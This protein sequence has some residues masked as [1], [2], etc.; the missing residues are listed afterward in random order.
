MENEVDRF[1]IRKPRG[2]ILCNHALGQSGGLD[3][4]WIDAAP[5][6]GHLD[7]DLVGLLISPE[8]DVRVTGFANGD[9]LLRRFDAV[10][11]AIAHN[12][13]QRFSQRGD[14][15]FIRCCFLA[16]HLQVD[17]LG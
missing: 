12:V 2:L 16:L 5:V 6:I 14:D 8:Q 13:Q 15:R 4:D 1:L 11:D 10:I 17:F 7:N 3:L 9:A